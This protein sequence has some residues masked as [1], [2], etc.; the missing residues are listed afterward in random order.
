VTPLPSPT[1]SPSPEPTSTPEPTT[2]PT[3]TPPEPSATP[4]PPTPTPEPPSPTPEPPT[5]TPEPPTPTPEPQPT[6]S[7]PAPPEGT[8]LL[9]GS[10]T[11]YNDA[12]AGSTLGCN[13]YGV[14]NPD[15]PTVIAVGPDYYEEW[16]CG[17]RLGLC[18][19]D[20]QSGV[21][22]NCI[23]GIRQDSCPG[24][25]SIHLD[26]S[27]AAFELLCGPGVIRC[28]VAITPLP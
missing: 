20:A 5:P 14:Y 18:G 8:E 4:E 23:V 19:I 22:T 12:L 6:S 26:V 7:L 21:I 15:D 3:E 9:L 17:T 27:R 24:C 11:S 25:I 28:A 16:P 2:S 1:P 13:G 10:I